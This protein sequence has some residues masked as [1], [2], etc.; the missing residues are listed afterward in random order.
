VRTHSLP[1][2]KIHKFLCTWFLSYLG[3]YAKPARYCPS[4]PHSRLIKQNFIFSE[5]LNCIKFGQLILR[6]I[7]KI[8]AT[9]CHILR[10]K[11]TKFDFGW[12]SAPDPTRGAHSALKSRVGRRRGKLGKGKEGQWREGRAWE[13]RAE[14]G[15]GGK[16]LPYAPAVANSWLRHCLA[17]RRRFLSRAT[18][19]NI[20]ACATIHRLRCA[21]LQQTTTL[22]F[23]RWSHFRKQDFK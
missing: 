5:R 1:V 12:G 14:E 8:V 6:K 17:H 19:S 20:R 9:R 21:I 4:K 15:R 13:G 7:I 16:E 11:C 10:L 18:G 2:R 23:T 22:S 3:L